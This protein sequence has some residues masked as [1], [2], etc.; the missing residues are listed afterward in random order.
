M[1]RI[2][3]FITFSILI[4]TGTQIYTMAS[5]FKTEKQKYDVIEHTAAYEIRYYPPALMA[6]VKMNTDNYKELANPGFRKLA[7]F[8]FGGNEGGNQIAMTS[9]VHMDIQKDE[10]V[11]SFVMP[12]QFNEGTLPK[13]VNKDI[14]ILTSDAEYLAA[15]SFG[16]YAND[17]KIKIQSEK[18]GDALSA[19]G[20]ETKG[21]YRFLGYNPPFQLFGRKN[22][23]IV[24]VKWPRPEH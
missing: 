13:P 5:L 8:I 3:L 14:E 12:G 11:M 20:I 18:L 22:E 15:L 1:K 21:N 10:S 6:R 7:G 23:I 2:L 17:K 24:R 4:L 9:P 16:G 19:A